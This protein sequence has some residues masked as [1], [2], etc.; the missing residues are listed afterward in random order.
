MKLRVTNSTGGTV[1]AR[2]SGSYIGGPVINGFVES[3]GP[4]LQSLPAGTFDIVVSGT[5]N[6][7]LWQHNVSVTATG[8][9]D[10]QQTTLNGSPPTNIVSWTLHP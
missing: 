8:Q 1:V 2:F 3:Y 7:G 6:S 4:F 5:F 10:T 9:N